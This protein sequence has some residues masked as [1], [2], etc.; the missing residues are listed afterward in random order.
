MNSKENELRCD[1]Y[2]ASVCNLHTMVHFSKMSN[3]DGS[4]VLYHVMVFDYESGKVEEY[5]ERTLMRGFEK[6]V[7]LCKKYGME[8]CAENHF[9]MKAFLEE[10]N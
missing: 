7:K 10:I 6:Y 2:I 1:K 9:D 3:Y 8:T 5:N 4:K